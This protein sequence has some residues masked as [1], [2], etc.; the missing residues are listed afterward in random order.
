MTVPA[1]PEGQFEEALRLLSVRRGNVD[2]ERAVRLIESAA[3]TG[4]PDAIER[5]AAIE[6]LGID[7]SPDWDRA[8]DS[9]A[10]AAEQG[11][12]SAAR[13]LLLF[14]EDR[15]EL[16]SPAVNESWHKVRSRVA[17]RT[18]LKSQPSGGRTLWADP[19]IHAISDFAS[20]AECRWL[21]AAAENRLERATVYAQPG[22]I[23]SGRSNRY[24]V[25]SLAGID[26]V[27][28]SIRA[29]IADEIGAPIGLLELPQVLHYAVGQEFALH[30]DFLDPR[31]LGDEIARLGQRAATFLIYL[32]ADFEGGATSFP[33]LGI[34]H[35][36]STGDG[37]V[38]S[39]LS[40]GQ[41]NFLAQHAGMPP[42]RG[43]KWVFS[44]WIRDRSPT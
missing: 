20:A 41:P 32:N 9:L 39:N 12:V 11:S 43:E 29:R 23:D 15:F 3:A 33:K 35:R 17:I 40:N 26:L 25:F 42:T 22:G 27:V 2:F 28:E 37:L 36:G 38:F 5:R 4:L 1:D 18:R 8:L 44:Q 30:Y 19:M 24:A 34:N 10:E 21:I 14:A 13:Q 7:R 16:D 6:C 31:I